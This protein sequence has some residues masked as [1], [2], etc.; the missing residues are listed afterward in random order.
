MDRFEL[1]ALGKAY[2]IVVGTVWL[3]IAG[4]AF[5]AQVA[6][7]SLGALVAAGLVVVGVVLPVRWIGLSVHLR[8]GRMTV[9]NI[10]RTHQLSKDQV[11]DFISDTR[12][13]DTSWPTLY[14]RLHDGR[15]LAMNVFSVR[16]GSGLSSRKRADYLARLRTWLSPGFTIR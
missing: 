9:R 10:F 6:A 11:E 5:A 14:V 8:E 1:P 7:H 12:G 16:Y 2:A 3:T 4:Y 13:L 15:V